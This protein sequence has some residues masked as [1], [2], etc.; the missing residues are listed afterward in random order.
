MVRQS[1]RQDLAPQCKADC[2]A[3]GIGEAA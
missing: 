1:P 2:I 3:Y